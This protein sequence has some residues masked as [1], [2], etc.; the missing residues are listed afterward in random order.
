MFLFFYAF[1][2]HF[3]HLFVTLKLS[4]RTYFRSEM[5]R[6]SGFS[7]AFLSLIRNFADA[8]SEGRKT[9]PGC[10]TNW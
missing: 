10:L 7:F 9:S 8:N 6:K 3:S 5:R 4:F 2:L 1:L